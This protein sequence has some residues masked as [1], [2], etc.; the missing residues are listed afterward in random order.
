MPFWLFLLLSSVFSGSVGSGFCIS[1]DC[2]TKAAWVPAVGT[3]SCAKIE[4]NAGNSRLGPTP[5]EGISMRKMTSR[6]AG[7]SV[8]VAFLLGLS[9]YAQQTNVGSITG[10]V[11]DAS[12]AV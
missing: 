6:L 7:L 3:S 2:L 11:H 1:T 5:E 9:L 12:G 10:T 8:A 4:L